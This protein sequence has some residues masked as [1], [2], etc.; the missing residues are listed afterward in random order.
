MSTKVLVLGA[1]GAISKH[2]IDFLKDD[3]N[4]ELSLFAR[5][6]DSLKAF[7]NSANII[8]G[9]VLNSADL[10][11]AI[12][13]QDIVYANLF[14]PMDEFGKAIVSS[15]QTNQVN[16]LI[17]VASLGI[18][19]EVPGAFGKWNN[20]IIGE[21]LKSYRK[22][23]DSIEASNLDYTVVRPAWLT[24]NDEVEF[25]TTQ[26]SEPFKGTEV[27]RK[28]VGAYISQLIQNPQQDSKA[29]IGV[30]KPNTDGDKPAFMD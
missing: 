11:A 17:F 15:M 2:V 30:N 16:R 9:D 26:K 20:N 7:A 3:K 13:G 4:I 14:G 27:S 24:D 8:Q 25:E 1:T 5:K 29:S 28:S 21:A 6:T 10:N 19:D 12:S 23:A 22:A 18:Y